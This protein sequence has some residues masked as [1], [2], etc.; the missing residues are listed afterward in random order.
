MSHFGGNCVPLN[1][2]PAVKALKICLSLFFHLAVRFT[3]SH[4]IIHPGLLGAHACQTT[5][6]HQIIHLNLGAG[7]S[8]TASS[9]QIIHPIFWGPVLVTLYPPIRLSIQILGG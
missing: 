5:S 2:N 8:Q 4:Q 3:S 6:S 7:A 1:R 9:H